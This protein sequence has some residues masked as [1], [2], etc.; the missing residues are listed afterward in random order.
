MQSKIALPAP[1]QLLRY[2]GL[3][4]SSDTLLLTKLVQ[5]LAHGKTVVV[6]TANALDAQRLY[7][8]I[9]FFSQ[10]P[11]FIY[12]LTGKRYLTIHS[13]LTTI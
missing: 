8:E 4:G 2:T 5:S 12:Y 3:T 6:I 9:P 13:H 11:E 1:G 7:E 10:R